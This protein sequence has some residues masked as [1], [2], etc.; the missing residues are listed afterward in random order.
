MSRKG[1][2]VYKQSGVSWLGDIPEHWEIRR[3]KYSADLI[4]TK[5][6]G[7][8]ADLPYTGLEHIESWTGKRISPNGDATSEGQAN[9][10]G[11]GD[12]L[13]GKL[14]PYLAKAH[15]AEID[16]IC[17]GELLVLRP[18]AV[19]QKFLLNYVLNSDFVAIVDSSTY[20]AKM[21]RANWE[22]IGNLPAL[23]PP[24]DEQQTIESFLDRETARIDALI[25]KKQKQIELLLEKRSSLISH[26]VTKGLD[27]NAKMKDSG[28][29]WLGNIPGHWKVI[30]LKRVARVG[31]GSTPSRENPE[32]WGD[33]GYPWLNSSVVNLDEV[34]EPVEFVTAT[35]LRKCHLPKIQ[36]PAVLVGI[37]G[38][39]KTRGMATTLRIES[40]INQ[41]LAFLKPNCGVCDVEYLRRVLDLMYHF[42]RIESEGA[43]STKGAITCEQLANL[44]IPIPPVEEQESIVGHLNQRLIRDA[45]LI[46]NI[47][48]SIEG[49]REYRTAL[50]SAAVT[51]KI[52][53]RKEV[54]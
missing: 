35:A 47:S 28:I 48:K 29:E 41:H 17:T 12:V 30:A 44:R 31:N 53:V 40:T 43:G 2:P 3:L 1:Y 36:P 54:S 37:T 46:S 19:K 10:Y 23:I 38:Q 49:L 26:A 4:N 25:E 16:G 33:E 42:L 5:I 45:N 15:A 50:I 20:G 18:K 9:L 13:F 34:I 32:Y 52:D 24:M 7:A 22:F 14:R 39:G 8:A 51:G 21:P 11:R 6:D 27:P